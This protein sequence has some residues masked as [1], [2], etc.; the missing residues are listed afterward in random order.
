MTP[1]TELA[2][3]DF[4]DVRVKVFGTDDMSP[5]I[6]QSVWSVRN[7]EKAYQGL[8]YVSPDR[9]ISYPP[10]VVVQPLTAREREIVPKFVAINAN[11]L[12]DVM[13]KD[14]LVY[15]EKEFERRNPQN[16]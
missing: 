14:I 3:L 4:H 11:N 16:E 5:N 9:K 12:T 6:I 15:L 1:F 13:T 10:G 7:P 8:V 2:I